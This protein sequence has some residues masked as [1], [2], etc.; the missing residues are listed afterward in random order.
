MRGRFICDY[1]AASDWG[2]WILHIV[3]ICT[4]FSVTLDAAKI[5]LLHLFRLADG[6]GMLHKGGAGVFGL[7][8]LFI[9]SPRGKQAAHRTNISIHSQWTTLLAG[10]GRLVMPLGCDL[11]TS[12]ITPGSSKKERVPAGT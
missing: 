8:Y 3:S 7:A 10:G 5:L 9:A 4:K 1:G 6:M 12:G 2:V 11:E